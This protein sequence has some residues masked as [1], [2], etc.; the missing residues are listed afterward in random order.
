MKTIKTQIYSKKDFENVKLPNWQRWLNPLNVKS[1]SEAV[2]ENGQLRDILICETK[3][4]IKILTDGNHL[5]TAMIDILKLNEISVKVKL[6]KDEEEA[7]K[8]FVSFNTK[9]KSLKAI[10]YIVSY[11]GGNP[12]NDY[13]IFLKDILKNPTNEKEVLKHYGNL[14]K[15]PALTQIFLGTNQQ[16]QSGK[17]IIIKNK[18]ER[19]LEICEYLE[20]NY[21]FHPTLIKHIKKNGKSQ[22]LNGGS[23]IPVIFKLR[24]YNNGQ[25]LNQSNESILEMLI[26]FTLYHFKSMENPTFTKDAVGKSFN[27]YLKTNE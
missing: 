11:S 7:R 13:S 26:E 18:Y 23:I 14:F 19:I 9:G 6:V 2:Q 4:G 8:T 5:K 12:N 20:Q 22:K 27:T 25:L 24:T 15:L 10:D 17:A 3:A 16:I 1:L 21:R